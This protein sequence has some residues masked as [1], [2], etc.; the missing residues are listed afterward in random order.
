MA[1]FYKQVEILGG[2][3]LWGDYGIR[4]YSHSCDH[5]KKNSKDAAC[6]KEGKVD[7]PS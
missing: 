2:S 5:V 4:L 6:A 7:S 1:A 3:C